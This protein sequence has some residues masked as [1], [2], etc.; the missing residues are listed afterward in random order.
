MT[1]TSCKVDRDYGVF[2]GEEKYG[3]PNGFVRVLFKNGHIYEGIVMKDSKNGWGRYINSNSCRI[4][5]WEGGELVS[6]TKSI[7]WFS[8]ENT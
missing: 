5:T 3:K 4:G 1:Y 7:R 6:E 2:I 8:E